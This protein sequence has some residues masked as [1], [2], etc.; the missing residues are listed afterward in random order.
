[1][2]YMNDDTDPFGL[3]YGN[4][5]TTKR[6]SEKEYSLKDLE[7]MRVKELELSNEL[8]S[9]KEDKEKAIVQLKDKISECVEAYAEI[10]CDEHC[11]WEII[12]KKFDLSQLEKLKKEFNL[13]DVSVE[14]RRVKILKSYE[15]RIVIKLE[16]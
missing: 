2:S 9:I 11:N 8:E 4:G 5:T 10:E 3:P 13:K 6:V 1:M 16:V 15:D 7:N 14:C 12:V